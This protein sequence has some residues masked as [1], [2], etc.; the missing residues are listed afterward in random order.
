MAKP[1]VELSL[2]QCGSQHK[3]DCLGTV[4]RTSHC[5]L[6][7]HLSLHNYAVHTF[8]PATV[9]EMPF[10]ESARSSLAPGSPHPQTALTLHSAMVSLPGPGTM[11]SPRAQAHVLLGAATLALHPYKYPGK[12]SV[13]DCTCSSVASQRAVQKTLSRGV[14]RIQLILPGPQFFLLSNGHDHTETKWGRLTLKSSRTS[15]R[16]DWQMRSSLP[17]RAGVSPGKVFWAPSGAG[18]LHS[19][20]PP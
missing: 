17:G 2:G 3:E 16:H 7:S 5:L 4:Y 10:C 8:L 15:Q 12:D 20:G 6:L 11:S 13:N 19:P 9:G 18:A 14:Q 1:G